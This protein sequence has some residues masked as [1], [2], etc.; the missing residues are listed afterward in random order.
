VTTRE[1]SFR[2]IGDAFV[3][4]VDSFEDFAPFRLAGCSPLAALFQLILVFLL[5]VELLK[6]LSFVLREVDL[7]DWRV[8]FFPTGFSIVV[9]EV[10][11]QGTGDDLLAF[12]RLLVFGTVFFKSW[13]FE[14]VGPLF[15]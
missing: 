9:G 7:L 5:G 1:E 12:G 10:Q 6:Q 3:D 4:E 11:V 2:P 13:I 8:D 15:D 14:N